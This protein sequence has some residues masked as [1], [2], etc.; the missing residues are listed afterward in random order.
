MTEMNNNQQVFNSLERVFRNLVYKDF[1]MKSDKQLLANGV[2][3]S[4]SIA[5]G[6]AYYGLVASLTPYLCH[7]NKNRH[8]VIES[9]LAKYEYL[10]EYV[11]R[12]DEDYIKDI[13]KLAEDLR[14]FKREVLDK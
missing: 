6:K 11:G 1:D 2:L 4:D 14:N 10:G 3:G 13:E 12:V 5:N 8:Y 9:F 7:N